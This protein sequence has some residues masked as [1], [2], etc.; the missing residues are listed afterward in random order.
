MVSLKSRHRHVCVLKR[1]QLAFLGKTFAFHDPRSSE[2][3]RVR[4]HDDLVA[5]LRYR[6]IGRSLC[7]PS[8]FLGEI[9]EIGH[10]AEKALPELLQV[11]IC[12]FIAASSFEPEHHAGVIPRLIGQ[13]K[14]QYTSSFNLAERA[15]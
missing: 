14:P 15:V 11:A 2:T 4:L 10:A 3:A 1:A 7:D 13:D 6:R 9:F 8:A 12:L 5:P